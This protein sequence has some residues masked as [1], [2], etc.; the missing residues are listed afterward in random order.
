M[1]L[2]GNPYNHGHLLIQDAQGHKIGYQHGTFVRQFPGATAVFPTAFTDL[3]QKP[4]PIYRI[5][6]GVDANVTLDG[7]GL[8]FPDTETFSLIGQR[9]D[10]AID[11]IQVRP[12]EKERIILSTT[13]GSMTY[14]SAGSQVTSPVFSVGLVTAPGNYNIA[15]RAL[16]LHRDSVIKLQDFVKAATLAISDASA[17]AQT[18]EI[19]LTRQVGG[20]VEDL[21]TFDVTQPPGKTV[22]VLYEQI[23][24]GQPAIQIV[25]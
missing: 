13:Q 16:P 5:P 19:H 20:K 12:N 8:K 1:W 14:F 3:N 9:H 22:N 11:R 24:N 2:Q 17:T 21:S 10:L 4:L 6:F 23:Q 25:P 7:F 15:V 18:F